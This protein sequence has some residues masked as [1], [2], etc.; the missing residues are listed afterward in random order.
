M[1]PAREK[2]AEDKPTLPSEEA[3]RLCAVVLKAPKM[4]I[5]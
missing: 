5:T 3:M 2:K 4:N 1:N